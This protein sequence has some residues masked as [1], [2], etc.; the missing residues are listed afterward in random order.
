LQTG[1]CSRLLSPAILPLLFL[2]IVLAILRQGTGITVANLY[3]P[4][5]LEFAGFTSASVDILATVGV[6]VVFVLTNLLALYLIDRVGRR[7]L[8][9]I[10]LGGMVVSLINMGVSFS[11]PQLSWLLGPIT[12]A[13]LMLFAAFWTIGPGT[14][15]FL[16]ISEIFPLKIRSL[17]M[18]LVT[19]ALWGTYLLVTVTFLSLVNLLGEPLTFWLYALLALGGLVFSYYRV[20]ETK[21]R[22]L[23][24]IEGETRGQPDAN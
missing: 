22:S 17:A 15:V 19:V 4:T 9:L 18:S 13:S 12:A 21:G 8:L 14:V 11:L 10:G 16:L 24:E 7:P 2:G 5:V 6:G 3:A 23:E 20:P 1:A